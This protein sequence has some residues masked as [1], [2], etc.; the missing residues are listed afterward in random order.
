MTTEHHHFSDA[1]QIGYGQCSYLRLGD[2]KSMVCYSLVMSKSRVGPLTP[3]TIPSLE[4]NAATA[5]MKISSLLKKELNLHNEF[6]WTDSKIVLG[7]F[8]NDARQFYIYVA[9]RAQQIRDRS[10]PPQW[11]YIDTRES[12]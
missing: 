9:N 6:S 1:S 5:S 2:D 10:D 12:C 3:V 8:A 4:L 11:R 7:Y